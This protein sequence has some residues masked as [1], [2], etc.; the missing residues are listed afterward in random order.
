MELK[1]QK[2]KILNEKEAIK[3]K[4]NTC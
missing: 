2:N 1:S 3:K 4:T